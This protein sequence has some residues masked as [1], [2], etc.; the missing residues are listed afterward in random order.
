M[1]EVILIVDCD[2]FVG[3]GVVCNNYDMVGFVVC[4][5]IVFKGK[6]RFVGVYVGSFFEQYDQL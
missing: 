2:D 5:L 1:I 6:K 3:E 4:V